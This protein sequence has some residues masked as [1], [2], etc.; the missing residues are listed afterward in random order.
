MDIMNR[1]EQNDLG[2]RVSNVLKDGLKS[3]PNMMSA[4]RI[5]LIPVI[6]VLYLRNN[7]V[8]AVSLIIVSAITD[9]FDGFVARK[10][11]M[12]TDLGKALDP[13]A[14]KL[15]LGAI[16]I[17]LAVWKIEFLIIVV[18]MV[19]KE[20]LGFI[21]HWVIFRNGGGMYGA[22]WYGKLSTWILYVTSGAVMIFELPGSVI[23]VMVTLSVISIIYAMSMYTFRCARILGSRKDSKSDSTRED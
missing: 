9:L 7:R 4:F 10:F 3:I 14:D 2:K 1:S 12:V 8:A 16:M 17:C 21:M 23:K 15:T 11:N 18:F 22:M 6:I 20:T 19:L 13:I 5:L